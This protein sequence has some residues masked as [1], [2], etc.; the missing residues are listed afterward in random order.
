[1]DR[2]LFLA[3]AGASLVATLAGCLGGTSGE[4]TSG[5][6]CRESTLNHDNNSEERFLEE[7]AT[8]GSTGAREFLAT[9]EEETDGLTR[10]RGD[11]DTWRIGFSEEGNTWEIKY[12]GTPHGGEDRF[13][14]EIAK[15]SPAFASNRPDGVSLAATSLHECTTG[16]W[17]V[18]A[19]PAGAY[20]RGELDRE[21]FVD[22]IHEN[23]EVVNNC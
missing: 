6:E 5:R 19:D 3:G 1:M 17:H 4:N 22:R 11:G 9:V 15:L 10:F 7:G 18:C 2:R 21:T 12:R 8:P 14:E 20:E 23:A 13:R 16:T